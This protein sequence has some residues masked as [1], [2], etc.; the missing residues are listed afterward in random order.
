[1]ERDHHYQIN[2]RWT[3]NRG[4]GTLD[5]RVY[6][7]SYE[8]EVSGKPVFK[9]SS[10]PAFRGD[11]SLYNPEDMLVMSLSACHMLWYLHL[12]AVSGI[13]VT[14]YRDEAKGT[15]KEQKGG[16]GAFTEVTL[17]PKVTIANA[18]KQEQAIALHKQANEKCFIANSVKFPVH[19]QPEIMVLPA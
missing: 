16:E 10:D 15:M 19:H 2:L 1:M 14:D 18:A 13:V 12:C 7:R 5:Y 17:Y 3:G 6:D 4:A 9:G 8:I 11:E